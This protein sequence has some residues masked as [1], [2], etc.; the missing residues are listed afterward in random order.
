MGNRGQG[1]DTSLA[2]PHMAC[3]ESHPVLEGKEVEESAVHRAG[4]SLAGTAAAGGSQEA[5]DEPPEAA[6]V[7]GQEHWI[8][9]RDLAQEQV[10]THSAWT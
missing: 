4:K 6:E 2:V 9:L 8:R 5:A 1:E 3:W 10:V 7:G